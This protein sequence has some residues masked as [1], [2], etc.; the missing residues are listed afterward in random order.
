MIETDDLDNDSEDLTDEEVASAVI[1]PSEDSML[2]HLKGIRCGKCESPLGK[3]VRHARRK[4]AGLQYGRMGFVCAGP[5]G[6]AFEITFR[7]DWL[8]GN[9]ESS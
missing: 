9:P 5:E 4:R 8:L 1:V 3:A 7:M 2:K 6:H